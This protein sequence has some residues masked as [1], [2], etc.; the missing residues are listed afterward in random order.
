MS[1]SP[2]TDRT[3]GETETQNRTQGEPAGQKWLSGLVSLIG[4]WIAASPFVYEATD[5]AIW[6][7]LIVGAA[8]F[9]IA[10][11]NYYRI[12]NNQSTSTGAMSLVVLLGLWTLIAPYTLE[13]AVEGAVATEGLEV[14]AQALVWSNVVTGILTALLAGYVGYMAGSDVHTG[15]AA[16]TR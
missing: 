12:T 10:G 6:N 14:A 9:L 3:T 1:E 5:A 16:E 7:N 13:W 15:T 11:Y 8:I 4:L 2:P